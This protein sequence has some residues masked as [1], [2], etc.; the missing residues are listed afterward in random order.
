[1]TPK[2]FVMALVL[3]LF[4]SAFAS[5]NFEKLTEVERD[6]CLSFAM[7]T[8]VAQMQEGIHYT[9]RT[10]CDDKDADGNCN[11]WSEYLSMNYGYLT[12]H[13]TDFYNDA[14]ALVTSQVTK[15]KT[16]I[17]AIGDTPQ[18]GSDNLLIE[19]KKVIFNL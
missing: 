15:T 6:P 9:R 18:Q 19:I 12:V 7:I 16:P 2:L 10:Y 1:M 17:S 3:A 13:T 11:T 14:G 4:N 8:P 5:S